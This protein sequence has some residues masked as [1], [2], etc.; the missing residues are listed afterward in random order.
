MMIRAEIARPYRKPETAEIRAND[1]RPTIFLPRLWLV[2]RRL[3]CAD[4][5]E[6]GD[7]IASR[8]FVD[9]NLDT[10]VSCG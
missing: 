6:A 3:R 8:V 5:R 2:H 9:N 4:L 1:R 10:T 7:G